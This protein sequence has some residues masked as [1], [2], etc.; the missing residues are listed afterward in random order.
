MEMTGVGA[1][2]CFECVG[3][4]SLVQEAYACCRKVSLSFQTQSLCI[5]SNIFSVLSFIIYTYHMFI[6]FFSPDFRVGAK[7][8]C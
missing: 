4:A 6:F 5:T 2:Y 3:N 7:Q 1:D 8:L